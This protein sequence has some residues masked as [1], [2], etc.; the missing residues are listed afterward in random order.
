MPEAGIVLIA[1]DVQQAPAPAVAAAKQ[2]RGVCGWLHA[3][4]VNAWQ[5]VSQWVVAQA[6]KAGEHSPA[7]IATYCRAHAHRQPDFRG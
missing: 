3:D 7:L 5:P 2:R 6:K 1:H 4:Y